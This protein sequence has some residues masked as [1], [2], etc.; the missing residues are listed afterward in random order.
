MSSL[1]RII[2]I[3]SYPKSGNTWMRSLLAHYFMPAGQAPDINNLRNFT[4]ADVRQDFY[5]A[6]NGGA[7]NGTDL[8]AWMRVRP[9]ALRLIAGSRP[10]HHFVKTHCQTIRLEGQDVIPPEVTSGGIYLIRNP[11]DL[12]PSFA[13]HQS[14]DIDTAIKRMCNPDTVM[15]TP[16]GIFDV[17]GRWDDHVHSWTSA[18]GL[19]RR[20]IRYE[21]LLVKPA[22]E[23]RGLLEVFLGQKVDGA[24]LARAIKA[25]AFDKMQK[26]EREHGFTEKPEGMA[27][28]FAKGQAGVWKDDLT[29]AQVGRIREAFLPALEQHYPEM[30]RETEEFARG[31]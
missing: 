5:D 4:T 13:R 12:A 21:D 2:W 20:V 18:P 25:T 16:T 3:A 10:N 17:L 19:K 15:G 6:A 1:K 31:G 7:Y 8:K 27:N 26:Q 23:M 22:R 28:F 30:L 9:G 14:A 24:K 11:F 29:P